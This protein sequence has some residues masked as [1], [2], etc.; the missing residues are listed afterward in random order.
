LSQVAVQ[1]VAGLVVV[2]VLVVFITQ[3]HQ[4]ELLRKL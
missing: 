4:L 3:Q 1:V 2:V